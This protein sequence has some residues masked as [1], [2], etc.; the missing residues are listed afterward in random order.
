MNSVHIVRNSILHKKLLYIFQV[1]TQRFL[2]KLFYNTIEFCVFINLW[3]KKYNRKRISKNYMSGFDI[4]MC[5]FNR[6]ISKQQV[7]RYYS[8]Y[9]KRY[10]PS[11][12]LNIRIS[13]SNGFIHCLTKNCLLLNSF[14]GANYAN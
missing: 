6:E 11:L 10:F 12:F 13:N 14:F 7:A 8:N 5:L 3:D 1:D 4:S 2:K 9:L